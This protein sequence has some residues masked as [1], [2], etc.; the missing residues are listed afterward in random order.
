[1]GKVTVG[2]LQIEESSL[3]R[4]RDKANFYPTP[5][6][7]IQWML[8]TM[9]YARPLAPF[10]GKKV[11]W[12]DAGVGTGNFGY[13]VKGKH[14]SDLVWG[15]ELYLDIYKAM[16]NYHLFY[17]NL[18]PGDLA[19]PLL[20]DVRPDF[21]I[22]NPPYTRGSKKN[23]IASTTDIVVNLYNLLAPYG[24]MMLLLPSNF[25]HGLERRKR[26]FNN[27][28]V[29]PTSIYDLSNRINFYT[30]TGKGGSYPSEYAVYYWQKGLI[31]AGPYYKGYAMKW[32]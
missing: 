22:G 29:C 24:E 31:Q 6:P 10:N 16:K 13:C 32:E 30:E 7:F 11:I 4:D 28:L 8:E 19:D 9:P 17:D 25:R 2:N 15:A 14:P 3:T 23:G 5:I 21:I 26:I 1:M 27:H 18:F 12:F 20:L